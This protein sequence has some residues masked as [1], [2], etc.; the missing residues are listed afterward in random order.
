MLPFG[1]QGP[2]A[3]GADQMSRFEEVVELHAPDDGDV[4]YSAL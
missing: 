3:C 1:F 2:C 4:N